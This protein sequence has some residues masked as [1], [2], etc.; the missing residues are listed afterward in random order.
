MLA[1]VAGGLLGAFVGSSLRVQPQPFPRGARVVYPA[2][3]LVVAGLVA[4]GLATS[5]QD[6]VTARVRLLEV[7][8]DAN[9]HVT[10]WSPSI[11]PGPPTTR[12]GSRRPRGRAAGWSSTASRA[13]ATACT[14]TTQPIPV[15]GD[16]KAMFRLH[17][18]RSLL[19]VPIYLPA[20]PAIPAKEVPARPSFERAFVPDKQILQR[21]AKEGALGLTLFAYAVVLVITLSIIALNAW[22]LVRLATVTED[23]APTRRPVP[24]RRMRAGRPLEAA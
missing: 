3:G 24:P 9:R 6:G 12:S 13:C 17:R 4:F 7:P 15:Y 18:G 2:A 8:G 11:R 20:D 21:E 23:P 19:G 10:A 1:G 5:P 22:A 14:A 16:W